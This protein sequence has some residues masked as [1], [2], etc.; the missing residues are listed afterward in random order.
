MTLQFW[1]E[2]EAP[3]KCLR[4]REVSAWLPGHLRSVLR[5]LGAGRLGGFPFAETMQ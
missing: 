5:H 3:W 1:L 2:T 4:V